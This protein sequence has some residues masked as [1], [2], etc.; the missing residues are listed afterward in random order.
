[1]GGFAISVPAG[2]DG[3]IRQEYLPHGAK[4]GTPLSPF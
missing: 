2:G 1:M 3:I 4:K